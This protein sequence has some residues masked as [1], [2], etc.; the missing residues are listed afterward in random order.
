MLEQSDFL[1]PKT[2][3]IFFNFFLSLLYENRFAP[4]FFFREGERES[5][6]LS[7]ANTHTYTHTL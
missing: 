5:D 7:F 6:A 3:T 2:K 4:E 1:L